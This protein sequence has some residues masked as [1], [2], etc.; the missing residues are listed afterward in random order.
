MLADEPVSALDVSVQASVLNLLNELQIENASTTLF[1]SHD[2]GVVAYLSDEIAVMYLGNLME[3]S[4]ADKLFDVPYHPYTEALLS[5]VPAPDPS[6]KKERIRSG[7]R[8]SQR[9]RC[10]HRLPL[11]HTLPAL[12]G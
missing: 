7:G 9:H 11:P 1:I 12:L 10:T 6:V 4:D 8:H 5:A 3:I 2:I